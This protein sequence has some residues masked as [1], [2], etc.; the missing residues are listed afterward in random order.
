MILLK[1]ETIETFEL[2]H[3]NSTIVVTRKCNYAN[4]NVNVKWEIIGVTGGDFHLP[5]SKELEFFDE[6][7]KKYFAN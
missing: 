3:G 7:E 4:R 5:P 1:T 2:T 6:L